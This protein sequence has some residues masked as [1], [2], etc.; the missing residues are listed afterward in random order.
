MKSFTIA[1]LLAAIA[2]A[3]GGGMDDECTMAAADANASY[4]G[5]AAAWG[6]EAAA[7]AVKVNA[8]TG[9]FSVTGKTAIN[10]APPTAAVKP[11]ATPTT[12]SYAGLLAAAAKAAAATAPSAPKPEPNVAPAPL[13]PAAE[14]K[15]YYKPASAAANYLKKAAETSAPRFQAENGWGDFDDYKTSER[16]VAKAYSAGLPKEHEESKA[17]VVQERYLNDRDKLAN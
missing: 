16:Q 2:S 9:D 5:Q 8:V 7:N 1:A 4:K 10:L 14:A 12:F 13:E 6:A 11:A 17:S 3:Y 15:S